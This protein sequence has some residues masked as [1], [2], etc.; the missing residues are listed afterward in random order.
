VMMTPNS[1]R[2]ATYLNFDGFI[3]LLPYGL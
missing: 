1:L 2:I 3:E